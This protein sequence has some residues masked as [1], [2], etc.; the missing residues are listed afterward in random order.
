MRAVHSRRLTFDPRF[1]AFDIRISSSRHFKR[2]QARSVFEWVISGIGTY[3]APGLRRVL[4]KIS[5]QN[6]EFKLILMARHQVSTAIFPSL[7][8]SFSPLPP[9]LPNPYCTA[10]ITISLSLPLK[11]TFFLLH[12]FLCGIFPTFR[13]FSKNGMKIFEFEKLLTS[14][15][16]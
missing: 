13:L 4:D 6:R 11:T 9:S 14:S 7:P 5:T 12:R 3:P 15:W 2:W 16:G 1:T 8:E 10:S